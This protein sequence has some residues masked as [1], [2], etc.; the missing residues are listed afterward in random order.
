[1]DDVRVGGGEIL[2]NSFSRNASGT[3]SL[4]YVGARQH[5]GLAYRGYDFTY[6][7]PAAG[8]EGTAIRGHRHEIVGRADLDFGGALTHL[9]VDGSAQWYGHDEVEGS[10]E[11]GTT[12]G[13]RTQTLTATTRT[14]LGRLGGAFGVTGLFRQYEARGEEALS[15]PADSRS[16]GLF[17]YQQ[18]PLGGSRSPSLE[19]GARLD[20]YRIASRPS[21]VERFGTAVSRDYRH[22]SGSVGLSMPLGRVASLAVSA[23]RAFRAPTVDELFSNGLHAALGTYDVGD[24][25]L[26]L[27][28]SRGLD[29]VLRAQSA[30]LGGQFA[31]YANWIDDYIAPAAVG[32][33]TTDEGVTV[34]VALY[35]QQDALLRGAE[36]QFELAVAPRWVL[37]V[38]GDVTRGSYRGG[39]PLPFMPAARAGGSVRFDD[40]RIAVGVDARRAFR[41]AR[42]ATGETVAPA[43]TLVNTSAS[44]TRLG[45]AIA[46]TVTLR[47]DN[48]L[49]ERFVDATSRIKAVAPNPG[50]NVTLVY[51][52]LF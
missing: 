27:E 45:R 5:G 18:L 16:G 26:A 40:R 42:V 31:V 11:I 25:T 14:R 35:G 13:L 43:Y 47:A 28:T 24:P 7:L 30:R 21:D 8:E 4:A 20:A 17:V 19:A 15:P 12:F 33:T 9:R 52:V 51:R 1:M 3:A 41:Q 49:D 36:G 38:M 6:G 50:R 34:P 48:L 46:H 44:Y 39:A 2:R 37:G 22:V 32:D 10:G 29:A 23:A